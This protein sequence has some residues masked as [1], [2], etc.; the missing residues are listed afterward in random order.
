M[1][2]SSLDSSIGT[3]RLSNTDTQQHFDL[4]ASIAD[5]SNT[6]I[7]CGEYGCH[8]KTE[9]HFCVFKMYSIMYLNI[10]KSNKQRNMVGTNQNMVGSYP[11]ILGGGLC[12]F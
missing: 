8:S 1:G 10:F 9:N 12:P 4:S 6:G 2:P 3:P 11:F 7:V 5:N